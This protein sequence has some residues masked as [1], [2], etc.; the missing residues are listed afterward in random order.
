MAA[1]SASFAGVSGQERD[2]NVTRHGDLEIEEN[3]EAQRRLWKVQRVG[4][5]VA[6]LILV[7]GLAGAFGGGPLSQNTVSS[8]GCSVEYERITY[9]DTPQLYR[10]KLAP[11]VARPGRVQVFIDNEALSRMQF[12]Q[13]VPAPATTRLT[14]DGALFE[15]E[16]GEGEGGRELRFS[17]Q[18]DAIGVKTTHL[19]IGSCPALHL[20]QLFLP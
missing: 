6:V 15:F 14:A 3:M 5:A 10:F 4:R 19:G 9:R 17:F 1:P 8:G 20:K 12:E 7:L 11:E 16:V 2:E 18:A 13:M